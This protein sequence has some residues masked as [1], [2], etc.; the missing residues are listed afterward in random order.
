LKLTHLVISRMQQYYLLSIANQCTY[1]N[2]L[3]TIKSSVKVLLFR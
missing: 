1:V 3:D 2:L